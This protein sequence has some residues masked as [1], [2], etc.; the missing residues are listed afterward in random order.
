MRLSHVPAIRLHAFALSVA[1][2]SACGGGGGGTSVTYV[3]AP[4]PAPTT[5]TSSTANAHLYIGT[6]TS[7]CGMALLSNHVK[8]ARNIYQ[9][10]TE[11]GL[12][13]SGTFEQYQYS[14][15]NC[16][17]QWPTAG[18][19]PVRSSITLKILGNTDVGTPT[20]QLDNF[21]GTADKVEIANR[22]ASGVLTSTT[23][24]AAFSGTNGLRFTTTL[25][26]SATG[27]VYTRP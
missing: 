25:P 4:L 15:S 13:V 23:S 2:L 16:A 6:W 18:F 22:T 7:D 27:L 24:F 21:V 8:S 10:T 20:G 1:F 26:F 19:P 11:D 5:L 17:T 14:D 12:G 3:P 9:L